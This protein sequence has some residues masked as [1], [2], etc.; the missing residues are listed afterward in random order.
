MGKQPCRTSF[1]L[2]GEKEKEVVQSEQILH[3]Q[4]EE[5]EKEEEKEKQEEETGKKDL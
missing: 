5:T 1:P 2:H 3:V 4:K